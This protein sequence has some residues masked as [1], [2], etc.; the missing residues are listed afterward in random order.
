MPLT[1]PSIIESG[2]WLLGPCL[3]GVTQVDI[4]RVRWDHNLVTS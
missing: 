2:E 1:P 4:G 3:S